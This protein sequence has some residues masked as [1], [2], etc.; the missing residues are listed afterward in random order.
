MWILVVHSLLTGEPSL[1]TY[2]TLS[3]AMPGELWWWHAE[4]SGDQKAVPCA[5]T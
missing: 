3:W 1:S 4:Q 2:R 5:T